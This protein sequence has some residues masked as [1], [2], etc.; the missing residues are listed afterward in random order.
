MIVEQELLQNANMDLTDQVA[1]SE[2]VLEANGLTPQDLTSHIPPEVEG[3]VLR[4]RHNLIAISLGGDDG[5]RKGHTFDI[6]HT[7]SVYIMMTQGKNCILI[8]SKSIYCIFDCRQG[9]E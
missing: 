7:F 6:Y 4:T 3:I 8:S 2:K 5:V 1:L 9:H